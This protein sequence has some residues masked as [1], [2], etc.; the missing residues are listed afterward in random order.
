VVVARRN[1]TH[2]NDLK[3]LAHE[4]TAVNCQLVGTVLN[5]V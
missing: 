5:E 3:T 1:R 2:V 4:H